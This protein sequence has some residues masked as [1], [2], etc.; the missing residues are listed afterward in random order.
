MA[1]P[2]PNTQLQA[3]LNQYGQQPNVNAQDFAQ[4]R[5][6]IVADAGLL[7][8]LNTSAANGKLNGFAPAAGTSPSLGSLDP[9]TGIVTLPVLHPTG[10]NITGSTQ[11]DLTAA[12]KLQEMSLRFAQDPGVTADMSRNLQSTFN[13]SP[14]LVD[15]TLLR[16]QSGDLKH[17]AL[18]TQ[19]VAGGSYSP[20]TQTMNLTASSLQFSSQTAMALDQQ[21][22]LT[23]VLGHELQHGENRH[24][25]AQAVQAASAEMHRVA[26]DNNPVN[27]YTSGI[28]MWQQA[29]REDEAKAHIAGWNALLSH[30]KESSG[31]PNAGYAQVWTQVNGQSRSRVIDF[32]ELDATGNPT[33]KPNLSFN[34]DGT[35][36][37]TAANVAATGQHYFDQPP[38]GAPNVAPQNTMGIGHHG[39]SDYSNTTGAAALSHA[40]EIERR[41]AIPKHGAASQMHVNMRQLHL[42]EVLIERNGLDLK[43]DTGIRQA[44]F[45]TSTQPPAQA[46]FDH[47][48]TTNAY[49]PIAS[50]LAPQIH[51]EAAAKAQDITDP[52]HP[53]HRR[54]QQ[55]VHSIEHS[56]NILPGTFTGER[57]QQ[58][59]AN[60]AYAS[61]AG[62]ERPGI[63][64]RNESLARIDFV[65]FNK[66]RSSLIAGEGDLANPSAKLAWLSGAHDNNSSLSAASQRISDLIQ[67]PQK[68]A[69]ANPALQQNIVQGVSEPELA[70]PRR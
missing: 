36:T 34:P 18:H 69:L 16:V 12:L 47:T 25:K 28:S 66:D 43:V 41:I 63:G 17:L 20:G 30:V 22:N 51:V 10:S 9:Q 19:G 50:E 1:S 61:L 58:S 57:L 3:A 14:A 15:Q 26:R 39:D 2:T 8:G 31:N 35:L 46:H 56:P 29:S 21:Q 68:Q 27:D 5:A 54:F 44:Y 4:L 70:G 67:D 64:G 24:A 55:A 13:G 49:V 42:N 32:L 38:K 60:L 62:E 40:I 6:A 7:Q 53:G 65:V 59:A 48:K 45:D 37:P 52:A 11:G 33:P 23:F